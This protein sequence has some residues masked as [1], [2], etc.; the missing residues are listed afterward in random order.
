MWNNAPFFQAIQE[1]V[2]QTTSDAQLARRLGVRP[3]KLSDWRKG[4][5][6]PSLEAI[7]SIREHTGR[8]LRDAWKAC[9]EIGPI[10]HGAPVD[11]GWLVG[12]LRKHPKRERLLYDICRLIDAANSELL[13]HL[14]S[15]VKLLLRA[16]PSEKAQGPQVESPLS[17]LERFGLRPNRR[18]LRL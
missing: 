7:E 4:I 15:T 18:K 13:R 2:G 9:Q 11:F 12:C 17:D 5:Y 6:R 1:F 16:L 10:V 3:Q 8:D 14:E